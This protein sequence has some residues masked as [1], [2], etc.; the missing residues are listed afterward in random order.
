M[1]SPKHLEG[2]LNI[3]PHSHLCY[4]VTWTFFSQYFHKF[5]IPYCPK[6]PSGLSTCVPLHCVQLTLLIAL[7]PHISTSQ[8]LK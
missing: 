1:I 3:Y 7:P 4:T 5:F 6:P 2:W 8:A